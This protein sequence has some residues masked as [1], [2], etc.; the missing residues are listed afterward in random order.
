[1]TGYAPAILS[2]QGLYYPAAGGAEQSIH[3]LLRGLVTH[4][5]HCTALT[6]QDPGTAAAEQID[7]VSVRRCRS[8]GMKARCWK[9]SVR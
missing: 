8:A 1:M 7:G 3:A 6:H 9:R 2:V 5:Y 4:G